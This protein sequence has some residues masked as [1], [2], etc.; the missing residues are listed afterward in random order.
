MQMTQRNFVRFCL[1]ISVIIIA[2]CLFHLGA[3][4]IKIGFRWE[5]VVSKLTGSLV[6]VG[7]AIVKFP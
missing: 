3:Y 4:M 6:V 1:G 5:I 7:G 2:I